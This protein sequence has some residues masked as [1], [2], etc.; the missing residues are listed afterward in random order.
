[1]V[2]R[3][4]RTSGRRC[5]PGKKKPMAALPK[6]TGGQWA[7]TWAALGSPTQCQTRAVC[8]LQPPAKGAPGGQARPPSHIELGPFSWGGVASQRLRTARWPATGLA[9]QAAGDDGGNPDSRLGHGDAAGGDLGARTSCTASSYFSTTW[10]KTHH[11]HERAF[12][13]SFCTILCMMVNAY[14]FSKLWQVPGRS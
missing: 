10:S 8:S 3:V 7:W 13:F 2:Y 1:M 11:T 12:S 14:L 5:K 6:L 9:P 4:P